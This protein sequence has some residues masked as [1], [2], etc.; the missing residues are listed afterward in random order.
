MAYL[1]SASHVVAASPHGMERNY[2]VE[3]SAAEDLGVNMS[4]LLAADISGGLRCAPFLVEIPIA[5]DGL[6]SQ[7][8]NGQSGSVAAEMLDSAADTWHSQTE[9]PDRTEG[10]DFNINIVVYITR[11]KAVH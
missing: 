5:S 9:T 11:K 4:A 3:R 8:A 6:V 7:S 1:Q 2:Y 10:L